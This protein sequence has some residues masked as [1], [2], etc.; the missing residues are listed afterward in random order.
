MLKVVN[1]FLK[2]FQLQQLRNTN[3]LI[4]VGREGGTGSI[5][6]KRGKGGR[7]GG[8]EVVR[9]GGSVGRSKGGSVG[10]SE[11]GSEGEKE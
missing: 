2:K 6:Y 3:T 11:I 4:G 10:G 7:E 8:R 9:E 1:V 5:E